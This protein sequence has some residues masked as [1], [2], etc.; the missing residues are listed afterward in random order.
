MV[1]YL[2]VCFLISAVVGI[3]AKHLFDKNNSEYSITWLEF[4]LT[5]GAINV[6]FLPLMLSLG[7]HLSKESQMT[8]KEY[9]NGW[10]E[11]A[12]A[13]KVVC[14]RDGACMYSYQ[15]DPYIV[16]VT[17]SCNCT[18][19][20][21]STCVRA[22]TRYHNCP[23][24]KYETN[25]Y[26]NTSL[27]QY[28]IDKHRFPINYQ[29]ERWRASESVP[30]RIAERAGIGEPTFW[31]QVKARI[32]SGQPGPVTKKVDYKNYFYASDASILRRQY[33]NVQSYLKHLPLP[34]T[35]IQNFYDL[36]KIY[37]VNVVPTGNI[38]RWIRQTNNVAAGMGKLQGDLR[39]V[40]V[41]ASLVSDPD[42]YTLALKAYW[43]HSDTLKKNAIAKNAV[44]F[45]F[46]IQNSRVS[47][48]RSFTTMP[49]GN[50]T[51]DTETR[52]AFTGLPLDVDSL[53]GNVR[54]AS[55]RLVYSGGIASMI[56]LPGPTQFR[57]ES[58]ENYQ[59]LSREIA[60]TMSVKIT[61]FVI[62]I[63]LSIVGWGVPLVI[64][65]KTDYLYYR[66]RSYYY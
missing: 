8:Y 14:H 49:K 52:T 30:T 61:L 58:M 20:G 38:N 4:G 29:A 6:I 51:I 17:Y 28:T 65:T 31:K 40:L 32:D 64:G 54:R 39:V 23:Y 3:V 47:W 10:E 62:A 16:M 35:V 59:Y 26:V 34:D 57:R 53:I 44:V 22:E 48:A 24:V 21:C 43:Q 55:G 9:L 46:G 56:L 11:S 25:Y 19:N 66:R 45:V 33:S 1:I 50:E 7:W 37:F 12:V 36:D 18:K 27:G 41:N 5:L 42:A 60:P 2:T 15:C 63:I 13:E